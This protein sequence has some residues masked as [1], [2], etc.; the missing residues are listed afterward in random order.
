[1]KAELLLVRFTATQEKEDG[2]VYL[3][4]GEAP[5]VGCGNNEQEASDDLTNGL[6]LY[7]DQL[8]ERGELDEVIESGLLSAIHVDAADKLFVEPVGREWEPVPESANSWLLPA[9]LASMGKGQLAAR[10]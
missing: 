6:A 4:C 5:I 8:E 3:I 7:L 9:S 10:V 1:M 2:K